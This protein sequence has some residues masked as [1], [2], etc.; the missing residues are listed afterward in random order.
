MNITLTSKIQNDKYTEYVYDAFD[1]QNREE[2]SVTIPMDIDGLN[3]FEWNVGV[4]Y[5]GSG[6]GK[7]TIAKLV[8]KEL[9]IDY[10]DTGA[11][12]RMVTLYFLQNKLDLKEYVKN[13]NL[14]IE[15]KEILSIHKK[16]SIAE[17]E[18]SA[19]NWSLREFSLRLPDSKDKLN[20]NYTAY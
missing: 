14:I 18:D 16:V 20:I 10:L 11:M 4:I 5:G 6:S 19:E 7:S 1:I 17:L 8:A 2:T 13:I 15:N 12:Y 3:S 9:N